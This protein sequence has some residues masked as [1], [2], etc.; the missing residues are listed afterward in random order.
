MTTSISSS[1]SSGGGGGGLGGAGLAANNSTDQ[2]SVAPRAEAL[3]TAI[4]NA[5]HDLSAAR[6]AR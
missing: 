4:C 2:C 5:R 1:S 3:C 6:P